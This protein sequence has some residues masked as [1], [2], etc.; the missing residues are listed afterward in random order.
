[1][2]IAFHTFVLIA[3]LKSNHLNL[4]FPHS[5]GRE[6]AAPVKLRIILGENNSQ[7]LIL[8]DGMPVCQ[9]THA[10]NK[11]TVWNK[12]GLKASIHGC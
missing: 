9:R 8:P 2:D 10:A 7:R 11:E 5:V 3:L 4:F 12:W 1:M 6:M